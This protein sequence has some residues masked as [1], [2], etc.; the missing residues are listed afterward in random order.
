MPLILFLFFKGNPKQSSLQSITYQIHNMTFH[1]ISGIHSFGQ[2]MFIEHHDIFFIK[3]WYNFSI[4]FWHK[5]HVL[6]PMAGCI[7]TNPKDFLNIAVIVHH[8]SVAIILY[9]DC[10]TLSI[11][12]FN[13]T[14]VSKVTSIQWRYH[15]LGSKYAKRLWGPLMI[16]CK[17]VVHE[18]LW[19]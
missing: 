14:Q 8:V 4:R 3:K 9:L 15:I 10:T 16:K 19:K 11:G 1:K 7:Y 5:F 6:T 17:S 18:F 2:P 12:S 13:R